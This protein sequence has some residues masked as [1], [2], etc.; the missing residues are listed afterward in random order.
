MKTQLA[1]RLR[2]LWGDEKKRMNLLLAAGL[3]GMLL[4][5]I[6]TWIPGTAPASEAPAAQASSQ[7]DADYAASL[8]AELEALIAKVDGAG[9][10]R[11]MVTLAAGEET[12]YA[13]DSESDADGSK[14][15]EHILLEGQST[16]AL[17]E[18]VLVPAVQG[19]A[20]LCEGGDNA[21]V[22]ARITEIVS[23][24]TGAGAS[25]ITVTKMAATQSR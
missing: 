23:V 18:N 20:V 8:Q 21:T 16:P 19:V 11:V 5:A 15:Q 25:H 22:Q 9:Q 17:I 6:S 12:L 10:T 3:V 7:P 13:T 4:L 1:V 24:L 2:A 14:K